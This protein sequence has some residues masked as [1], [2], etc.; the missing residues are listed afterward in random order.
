MKVNLRNTKILWYLSIF[1]TLLFAVFLLYL[2]GQGELSINLY[3]ILIVEVWAFLTAC[4]IYIIRI[5]FWFKEQ[6]A[7]I[8]AF[9]MFTVL[10]EITILITLFPGLLKESYSGS[11]EILM[12]V[13][14]LLVAF[15]SFTVK[16]ASISVPFKCF[17]AG[18]AM[19][20]LP[21][22]I[23][24]LTS[25]SLNEKLLQITNDIGLLIMLISL[26]FILNRILRFLKNN[27][28]ETTEHPVE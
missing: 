3:R 8:A 21:Q 7:V 13:V 12:E 17:G 9:S 20:S 11:V 24:M 18:I 14:S 23:M 28:E 15:R 19:I 25:A 1:N 4:F 27:P 2:P 5:L 22:L 6:T 16:A 26:G 10:L